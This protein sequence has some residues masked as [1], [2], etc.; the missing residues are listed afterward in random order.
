MWAACSECQSR[1]FRARADEHGRHVRGRSV[2]FEYECPFQSLLI[3]RVLPVPGQS[4]LNCCLP[5]SEQ[6][7]IRVVRMASCQVLSASK[8][9]QLPQSS[10]SVTKEL[11]MCTAYVK[12]IRISVHD[13]LR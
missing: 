7:L 3:R 9:V 10:L 12:A 8:P 13:L 6:I 2:Q 11:K 4:P 1:R 5:L